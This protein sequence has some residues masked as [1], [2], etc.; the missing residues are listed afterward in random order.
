MQGLLVVC[1]YMH[2]T[3]LSISLSFSTT[4]KKKGLFV[5]KNQKKK[6]EDHI[7]CNKTVA[8]HMACN[9]IEIARPLMWHLS[10]NQ[11]FYDMSII[12]QSLVK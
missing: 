12:E 10:L 5:R 9:S 11:A 6:K 4:E 3:M 8:T 1:I 7:K 2:P